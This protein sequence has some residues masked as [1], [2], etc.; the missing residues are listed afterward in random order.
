MRGAYLPLKERTGLF[1]EFAALE[2]SERGV[3]AFANQF[4]VLQAENNLELDSE[5]G[6]V[7][8]HVEA[9]ELG[10]ARSRP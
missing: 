7:L 4:G 10:G 1:R 6:P 2:P 3:L 9:L 5:F 8:A